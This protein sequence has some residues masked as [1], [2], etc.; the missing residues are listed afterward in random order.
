VS[1]LD[2]KSKELPGIP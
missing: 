2:H 1:H